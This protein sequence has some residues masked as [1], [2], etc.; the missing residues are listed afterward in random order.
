MFGTEGSDGFA[1]AISQTLGTVSVTEEHLW[2]TVSIAMSA[3]FGFRLKAVVRAEY[4]QPRRLELWALGL[5][6]CQAL[7]GKSTGL[8]VA[9]SDSLSKGSSFPPRHFTS[10][11]HSQP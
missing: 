4:R 9:Y 7:C 3:L 5:R 2:R 1:R 8:C 6:L 10:V 11:L